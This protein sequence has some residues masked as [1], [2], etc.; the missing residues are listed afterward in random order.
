MSYKTTTQLA[1]TLVSLLYLKHFPFSSVIFLFIL[2][3]KGFAGY[4]GPRGPPGDKGLPGLPGNRGLN[5]DNGD[6]GD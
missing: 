4:P 6:K 2:G 3:D 1:F 5:G